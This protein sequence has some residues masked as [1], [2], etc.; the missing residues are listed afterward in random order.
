MKIN[1][2]K[3]FQQKKLF[4]QIQAF[5][6]AWQSI[7]LTGHLY[8]FLFRKILLPL[9]KNITEAA[10]STKFKSNFNVDSPF[11]HLVDQVW[12][13]RRL[14][15]YS[16]WPYMHIGQTIAPLCFCS[17]PVNFQFKY[18]GIDIDCS[19]LPSSG[20]VHDDTY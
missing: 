6:Y 13:Q 12:W 1:L 16:F 14:C 17:S 20:T 15:C 7:N 19:C 3:N 11:S 4:K 18:F 5:T 10:N 8:I 2:C 9:H